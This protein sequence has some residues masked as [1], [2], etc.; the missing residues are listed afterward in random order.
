MWTSAAA[1]GRSPDAP[2]QI[3]GVIA[4]IVTVVQV[5]GSYVLIAGHPGSS[6][7]P[8]GFNAAL[9]GCLLLAAGGAALLWR[10]R[11]PVAVL[12]V[13]LV[14]A[15][16]AFALG[17][18]VSSL[19]WIVAFFTAVLTRHRTAAIASLAIVFLLSVLPGWIATNGAEPSL[20]FTLGLLAWLLALFCAA[21]LIRVRSQRGVALARAREEE[22][23]RRAIA[24]RLAIARDLHDIVAHNIS[25][26]NV[27]ANTALHL[28]DR[29][30]ERARQALSA[31][32]EVSR[33]ALTELRSV[34]GVLRADEAGA[35]RAP[36]P[37]I[38]QL[39]DLASR[40]RSAGLL[41][42]L[43]KKANP[44]PCRPTSAWPPTGSSRRPSPTRPGMRPAARPPSRS[45]TPAT[46]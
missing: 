24:E 11:Y 32:H 40:A 7:R 4:V 9:I 27:Q 12:T 2:R 28:M 10:R 36:G 22:V 1:P 21:E 33:Q 26:I 39:E 20:A 13:T 25:V 34:L 43:T 37:G 29:Q 31:I 17:A 14:I 45:T 18:R 30:P 41:V 46:P 19:A 8:A 42:Q 38:D 16:T 6:H 35:P 3:D 15:V 23:E 5:A 44:D